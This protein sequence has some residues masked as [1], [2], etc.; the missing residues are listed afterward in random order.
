[1]PTVVV[2][3]LIP[4]SISV[5]ASESILK[6]WRQ[7]R[8]NRQRQGQERERHVVRAKTSRKVTPKLAKSAILLKVRVVLTKEGCRERA[9]VKGGVRTG[10]PRLDGRAA[11]QS[12][13]G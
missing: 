4:L 8:V 6:K 1:V 9:M 13:M 12:V 5:L 10:I 2:M 7:T 11:L 3:K